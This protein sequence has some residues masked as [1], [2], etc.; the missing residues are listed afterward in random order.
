MVYQKIHLYIPISVSFCLPEFK[1]CTCTAKFSPTM[2]ILRGF[3]LF[4]PVPQSVCMIDRSK[5]HAK[6]TLPPVLMSPTSSAS[7]TP[8]CSKQNNLLYTEIAVL[9]IEIITAI[10]NC[11]LPRNRLLHSECFAFSGK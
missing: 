1:L 9:K 11:T 3:L 2:S 5:Y 6:V 10:L 8:W 7:S 4:G